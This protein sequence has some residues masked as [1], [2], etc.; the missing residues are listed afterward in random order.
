[1]IELL[2][3]YFP[4]ILGGYLILSLMKL[5][6]LSLESAFLAGGAFA[7]FVDT[8][9][10][11]WVGMCGGC[12]VGIV[13]AVVKEGLGLPYLLATILTNGLFHGFF[14]WLH[15]GALTTMPFELSQLTLLA[16]NGALLLY[17]I[18]L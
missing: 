5:P 14:L 4:L 7:C 17:S 15:G 16:F 18:V 10:A 6:D 9:L 1:M 13:V 11:P 8:S 3:I 2:T 12:F